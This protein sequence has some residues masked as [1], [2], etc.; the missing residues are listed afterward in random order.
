[1]F[2]S[3]L[4]GKAM[5]LLLRDVV[6]SEGTSVELRNLLK[7][8]VPALAPLGLQPPSVFSPAPNRAGQGSPTARPPP[9][10]PV[11]LTELSSLQKKMACWRSRY[12]PAAEESPLSSTAAATT[13]ACDDADTLGVKDEANASNTVDSQTVGGEDT[14]DGK[15]GV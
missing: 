9:P 5:G 7:P 10:P 14:S 4:L 3:A 1:M 2:A 6:R 8:Y 11:T 13:V 15:G 12:Q